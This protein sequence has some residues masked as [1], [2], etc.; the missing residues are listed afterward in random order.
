MIP[1]NEFKTEEE[2]RYYADR[3]LPYFK[4]IGKDCIMYVR[5]NMYSLF[6]IY[7]DLGLPML[8]RIKSSDFES[9]RLYEL[10]LIEFKEGIEEVMD[11]T[12]KTWFSVITEKMPKQKKTQYRSK[13]KRLYVR[14]TDKK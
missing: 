6:T 10:S 14:N 5:L 12:K 11:E 9:M 1:N 3:L 13:N 7:A 2:A 8:R 4:S